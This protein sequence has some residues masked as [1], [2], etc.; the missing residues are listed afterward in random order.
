MVSGLGV[1]EEESAVEE[2]KLAL[3][4]SDHALDMGCPREVGSENHTQILDGADCVDWVTI[5]V[6]LKL[7]GIGRAGYRKESSFGGVEVE[8]LAPDP[9]G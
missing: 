2:T 1:S 5:N 9:A 7:E 8:A 6:K 3:G 4:R